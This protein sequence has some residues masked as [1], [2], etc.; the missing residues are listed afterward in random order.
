M[1]EP[2]TARA[3]INNGQNQK[4]PGHVDDL[5]HVWNGP[6][7]KEQGVGCKPSQHKCQHNLGQEIFH[8]NFCN[9]A[10]LQ[11]RGGP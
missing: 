6:A 4:H 3:N 7:I 1:K 2:E 10:G 9:Y 11:N 5:C 8:S